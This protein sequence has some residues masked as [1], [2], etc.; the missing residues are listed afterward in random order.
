MNSEWRWMEDLRRCLQAEGHLPRYQVLS[1]SLRDM[2]LEGKLL[3]GARLPPTRSVAEAL[4]CSRN[5][6]MAAFEQLQGAGYLESRVGSGT[7]VSNILPS[8]AL[9]MRRDK[10][11]A[12]G[13]QRA[14]RFLS[15]RGERLSRF[16]P[17]FAGRRK[18]AFVPAL[19]DSAAFPFDTWARIVTAVQRESDGD[20]IGQ[21]DPAGYRPLRRVMAEYLGESQGLKVEPEQ[22]I[23]TTGSLQSLDLVARML[24][25]PG[26]AVWVEDPGYRPLRGPLLSADAVLIPLPVDKEGLVVKRGI[27]LASSARMALV[28]PFQQ[29]PLAVDMSLA[30]KLELL[31]WAA[32]ANAWIVE[33]RFAEEFGASSQADN[34]LFKMD[35]VDR[36]G[37]ERVVRLG[38]FAKTLFPDIRLGY[39]VVPEDLAEAFTR[40]RAST[41]YTFSVLVQ[42]ALA[43]FIEEGYFAA[44]LRRL[45]LLYA[46]R[47]ELMLEGLSAHLSEFLDVSQSI[48]GNE[49]CCQLRAE[50]TKKT[51]D[52]AIEKACA[53]RGI[54]AH[55]LS[56]FYLEQPRVQG[57]VLGYS[58]IPN[59][60]ILPSLQEL[61][62]IIGELVSG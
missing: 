57:F 15:S 4:E 36:G 2:I 55:A 23:L 54:T 56:K 48:P 39:V 18:P 24:L 37:N 58:G 26:D 33:D 52:T 62:A 40:A 47:H 32:N 1:D 44:H 8:S 51:T 3:P 35:A 11:K 61:G 31:A 16:R 60:Q 50:V 6:V 14:A 9:E 25:D 13:Q 30:R 17:Q 5:T 10:T 53:E 21:A 29:F 45:R 43:R 34:S 49:I 22:I 41:D 20:I 28:T 42:P 7:Y 59:D 12:P 46:E 19:P 38:S 27:A